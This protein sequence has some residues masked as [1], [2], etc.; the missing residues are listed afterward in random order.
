MS[1]RDMAEWEQWLEID[2]GAIIK[3]NSGLTTLDVRRVA[4]AHMGHNWLYVDSVGTPRR[5][6]GYK[7]TCGSINNLAGL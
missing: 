3:K 1:T 2:L 7:Y 4:A 5:V 6:L